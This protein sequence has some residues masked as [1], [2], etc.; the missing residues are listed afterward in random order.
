M[1]KVGRIIDKKITT[2]NIVIDGENST[3]ENTSG[4]LTIDPGSGQKVIIEESVEV[5]N[6]KLDGNTIS[7]TNTNGDLILDPN[8]T[9]K[10]VMNGDVELDVEDLTVNGVLNVDN[11]EVSGNSITATDTNGD[12]NLVPD[13]TGSVVLG[14][15]SVTGTEVTSTG[16]IELTTTGTDSIVLTTEAGGN[17]DIDSDLV[18]S[19]DTITLDGGA[20]T[21][22]STAGTLSVE[23]SAAINLAPTTKVEVTAGDLEVTAG[24]LVLPNVT[25]DT[26]NNITA[27]NT[28]GSLTLTADGT[29]VINLSNDLVASGTSILTNGG[30]TT[31][32]HSSGDYTIDVSSGDLNL[33]ATEVVID[34]IVLNANTISTSTGDLT[35]D[36]AATGKVIMNAVLNIDTIN[37]NG[38]DLTLDALSG[39]VYI[40]GL[41]VRVNDLFIG[42]NGAVAGAGANTDVRLVPSGTGEVKSEATH[43]F[44][45]ALKGTQQED[46]TLYGSSDPVSLPTTYI[47]KL[48]NVSSFTNEVGGITAPASDSLFFVLTN[49][50]GDT[51][52]VKNESSSIVTAANRILTGT[53]QDIRLD[54]GASLYMFYDTTDSRWRVIGGSGGGGGGRT[55]TGT[56]AAPI[57]IDATGITAT[58]GTDED[59]Y[60][61]T[62]SGIV[63]VTTN[64]QIS[65]GTVDGQTLRVIGTS[66]D[67]AILLEDGNGIAMSGS[68]VSYAGAILTL[69]WDDSAS[70]WRLSA[71]EDN[72]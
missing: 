55:V 45:A 63:D 20:S 25:I 61:D 4:D 71:R 72:I 13:G 64:P 65:A 26:S 40:D 10:I 41:F 11:L 50:G 27:T 3:I 46:N 68:W 6:I 57:E 23:S 39:A 5:D 30:T 37:S 44:E 14:D 21:L 51:F 18:V 7:T 29:G 66:D 69:R 32:T 33:T 22:E 43:T 15:L 31:H 1:S 53:G 38:A 70:L 62:A 28:N 54:D 47:K 24:D 56:S 59:I 67:N 52:T 42:T 8:G 49:D 58:A 12:I 48:T 35:I 60:V 17:V 9:G 2:D 16:V 34:N 19:G 36:P